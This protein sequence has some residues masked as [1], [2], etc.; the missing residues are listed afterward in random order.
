MGADDLA[1]VGAT[2]FFGTVATPLTDAVIVVEDGKVRSV[3]PRAMVALPKGVPYI[4][5]R[6]L[7]VVPGQVQ[8][9]KVADAVRKKVAGGAPFARALEEA[10]RVEGSRPAE[11]TIEPGQ[12]ADLVLL[13]RDPRTLVDN[14]GSVKRVF[15]AGREVAR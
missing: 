7:F 1:I 13:E 2:V 5:G 3:G 15:V 4:D 10:L 8:E 9:P 6:R 12:P 11:A 14:L